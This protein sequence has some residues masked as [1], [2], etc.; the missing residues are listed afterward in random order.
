MCNARQELADH[1]K[2]FYRWLQLLLL[3]KEAMNLE[4]G[5]QKKKTVWSAVTKSKPAIWCTVEFLAVEDGQNPQLGGGRKAQ[6][7]PLTHSRRACVLGGSHSVI[8]WPGR[9]L[10]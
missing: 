9:G 8:G 5:P 10:C 6:T 3:K 4:A 2:V 7:R 1:G